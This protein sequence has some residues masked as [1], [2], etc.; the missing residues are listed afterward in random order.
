MGSGKIV[1]MSFDDGT[2][3]DRKLVKILDFYGL[4]A[5]FFLNSGVLGG[6]THVDPN[7]IAELYDQHE[8][9]SHSTHHYH[10]KGWNAE[11]IR[12]EVVND[13]MV[14]EKLC[15]KSVRGF[16]YPHGEWDA[17][18]LLV[19]KSEFAYARG[20]STNNG[21]YNSV[22]DWHLWRPTCHVQFG[23]SRFEE[24]LRYPK[25]RLFHVWGHSSELEEQ[26]IWRQFDDFCCRVVNS[27]VRNLTCNQFW[28]LEHEGGSRA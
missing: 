2:V 25:H 4:R 24:F 6:G 28:D 3:Y 15:G 11:E 16:S 12:W 13:R 20:T 18:M 22:R 7:E 19:V 27:P 21:N 10:M 1:V 8:V 26:G 23:N 9:A 14:L 5:T 17:V